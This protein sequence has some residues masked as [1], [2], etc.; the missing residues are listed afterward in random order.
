MLVKGPFL[1]INHTFRFV[2]NKDAHQSAAT[3]SYAATP[4]T[5]Q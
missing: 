4:N 1:Q 2:V 5:S 3:H